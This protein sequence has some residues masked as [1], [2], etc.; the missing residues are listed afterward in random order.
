[1]G[2]RKN[3]YGK[4]SKAATNADDELPSFDEKA[5][6]ALTEKIE[7]GLGQSKAPQQ[8]RDTTGGNSKQGKESKARRDSTSK[9]KTTK[10]ELNR[11]IKRD[12]HGNVKGPGQEKAGN[13][14]RATKKTRG[15]ANDAGTVLLQEILALG[16]TEEDLDLVAGAA[17]DDENLDGDNAPATDKSF[18][19]D[20]AKFVAGLG[21]EGPIDEDVSELEGE[22]AEE[23]QGEEDWE[24]ASD[25]DSP[26]DSDISAGPKEATQ[27]QTSALPDVKKSDVASS[28]GPNRLVS[29]SSARPTG[30]ADSL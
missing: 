20:L 21:I 22:D 8:S 27:K 29:N 6:F 2:K 9:S 17:S 11:G 12:A 23:D 25:L 5:L 16:G 24:E 14:N 7:K 13:T 15:G 1:M 26:A 3:A 30:L 4:D 28:Q 19:K 10:S 18:R